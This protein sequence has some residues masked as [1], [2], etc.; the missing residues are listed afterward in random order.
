MTRL[1]L[2]R[3]FSTTLPSVSRS[4]PCETGPATSRPFKSSVA[5]G[6]PAAPTRATRGGA[7][8]VARPRLVVQ[9]NLRGARHVGSDSRDNGSVADWPEPVLVVRRGGRPVPTIL[10]HS[11]PH[12]GRAPLH[13]APPGRPTRP[14][15]A[16]HRP[17]AAR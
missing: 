10:L 3:T 9:D 14:R 15:R 2:P 12:Q 1:M 8:S 13:S 4:A 7:H 5:P 17:P 11:A 6:Q 16:P